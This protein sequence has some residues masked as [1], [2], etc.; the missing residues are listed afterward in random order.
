MFQYLGLAAVFV[1]KVRK[2]K[3]KQETH[4]ICV[5]FCLFSSSEYFKHCS[6]SRRQLVLVTKDQFEILKFSVKKIL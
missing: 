1:L 4:L 5:K 6:V 3:I 2:Q